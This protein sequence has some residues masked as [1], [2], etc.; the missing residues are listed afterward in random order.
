MTA[1][2]CSRRTCGWAAALGIVLGVGVVPGALAADQPAPQSRLES[3]MADLA[4]IDPTP[5]S[6][7]DTTPSLLVLDAD[8]VE[9]TLARLSILRRGSTWDRVAVHDVELGQTDLDSRWLV[10]LGE[11]H[12]ALIATSP[13]TAP[14]DG[15][16]VVVGIE[17]RDEAGAPTLVESAR[18]TI[19]RA[20]EDAGAA[21]VDGLGRPELVL[22]LRPKYDTS[23]SCGTTSLDILDSANLAVRRSIQRP[24]RLGY[25]VIGR[26]DAMPGDDLLVHAARDCPPG[27][28][29]GSG[30]FAI[31]LRDGT[32]TTIEGQ[33]GSRDVTSFPPPLRISGTRDRD[34]AVVTTQD[35]IGV[36]DGYGHAPRTIVAG[37]GTPIVAGPDKSG[38]DITRMAW[39]DKNGLHSALIRVGR[40][41][42]AATDDV[43]SLGP[44]DVGAARWPLILAAA[45]VDVRVHGVASAWLGDLAEADCPDL[46]VPGAIEPCGS[47]QLRS[48]ASW[49]ATRLVT[50]LPVDGRRTA[51]VAA[52]I[53][54]DPV[55]G[56][57]TS[58]TPWAAAPAGW[59]RHGPSSPF[60]V[61][62]TRATDVVYYRD[63]PVPKATIEPT[64][65]QDGMTTMPGF[66]GT[67]M[68]VTVQ[69]LADDE[70]GPTTVPGIRDAFVASTSN[71]AVTRIVRVPVPPGNESGRDGAY[72]TL[73]LGDIKEAGAASTSHWG[74]QVVAINDWG[75]V[76]DPVVGT[77]TRD[78]KGPTLNLETPFTNPVWPF[79]THLSGR[80]EPGS[81]VTI[82]G[83]TQIDVDQ[84]G[85]FTVETRLA[86]WPQDIRLTATDAS[87]NATDSDFSVV[88]GVDY[89]QF[90][91][92]LIVAL[93]LLG[94]VAARGLRAA[95]RRP[96][97]F[98]PTPWSLG[99]LDQDA[100]PEIEE[101]PAGSGLARKRTPVD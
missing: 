87:G 38:R 63:F 92:A 77:V 69:P 93:T 4:V 73:S 37:S 100:M 9:P 50:V 14:G 2:N 22:G 10:G 25:G 27:G 66:T 80:T 58:P 41:G 19:D 72:T 62:E 20:V 84:R 97:G 86:P 65:G 71:E 67:R 57:P 55:V 53:G 17:V 85:R 26:F 5:G 59:W 70:D 48:A 79:L 31:R 29:A 91:W 96:G 45:A 34:A 76:G 83:S 40:D 23:G 46:V 81:K 61:S 11:R 39:L 13:T 8:R 21:D 99:T 56:I 78:V 52:G 16:A 88:G 15:H 18:S 42:S 3:P 35:G 6:P 12:Y 94:I 95:G 43:G 33:A 89:R 28:P 68:F 64:T 1:P 47:D 32:V 98:E 7:A 82:D 36:L 49:V 90:P 101:L 54:W 24:G 44:R 75:E 30:V 74:L 60:V 51:L